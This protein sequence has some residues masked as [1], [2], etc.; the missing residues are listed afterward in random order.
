MPRRRLHSIRIRTLGFAGAV[1]L[2]G[3]ASVIPE[4][5]R[6]PPPSDVRI[7]EVRANPQSFRGADVRWGGDIVAVKNLRT[8]T[9][10]EVAA[11][12]LENDGRPRYREKSEGRFLAKV[13]GFLDPVVFASGREMTVRG[14]FEDI[15]ERPIGEFP[16]RFPLVRAEHV[17]LWEPLPPTYYYDPYWWDPWYPWGWPRHRHWPP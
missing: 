14:R 15:V 3:C 16:Y 7:A 8:E 4:P 2:C 6:T 12:E 1:L 9:I 5:I 13:P 10:V 11:R 17:Y